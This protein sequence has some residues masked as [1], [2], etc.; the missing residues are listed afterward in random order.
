MWCLADQIE[1]PFEQS[2]NLSYCK[3]YRYSVIRRDSLLDNKLLQEIFSIIH[4]YFVDHL[5]TWR[6]RACFIQEA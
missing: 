5:Y 1:Y 2:N 6:T 3:L 4:G